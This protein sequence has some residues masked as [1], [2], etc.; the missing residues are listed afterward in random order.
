VLGDAQVMLVLLSPASAS[1]GTPLVTARRRGAGRAKVGTFLGICWSDGPPPPAS[2]EAGG[3]CQGLETSG[4][5][6]AAQG[7][8]S[9]GK[10]A[11]SGAPRTPHSLPAAG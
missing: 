9:K 7:R 2:V 5:Y 11:V 4:S 6:P 10:A 3:G 8:Q 1:R